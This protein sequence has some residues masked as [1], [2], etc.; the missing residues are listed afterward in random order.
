MSVVFLKGKII[1][2]QLEVDVD[3]YIAAEI[4]ND[5]IYVSETRHGKSIR[6]LGDIR[7]I[8]KDDKL[9]DSFCPIHLLI[10][11]SPCEELS[12]AKIDGL[13]LGTVSIFIKIF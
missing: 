4:D 2:D 7:E 10:G 3:E 5:A 9:I 1:A 8:V 13:G 12:R 6:H 11:G